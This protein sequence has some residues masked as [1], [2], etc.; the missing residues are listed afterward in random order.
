MFRIYEIAI[1]YRA[2]ILSM[3]IYVDRSVK[4]KR[5]KNSQEHMSCVFVLPAWISLNAV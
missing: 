1:I 2:W 3:G 5:Y 4:V